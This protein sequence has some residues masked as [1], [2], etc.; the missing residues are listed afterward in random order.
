MDVK[1]LR[2]IKSFSRLWVSFVSEAELI[3][4]ILFWDKSKLL[5]LGK[6][7][8]ISYKSKLF[9]SLFLDKTK[10]AMFDV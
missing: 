10:E 2:E 4:A 9:S 3:E 8:K 1:L 7:T 5:R 6:Q